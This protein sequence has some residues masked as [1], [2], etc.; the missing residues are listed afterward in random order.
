MS[1][2]EEE[3]MVKPIITPLNANRSVSNPIQEEHSSFIKSLHVEETVKQ[4]IALNE[5]I[6]HAPEITHSKI[7]HIKEELLAGR[8]QIHGHHIAEKILEYVKMKAEPELA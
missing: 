5:I 6:Q 1:T 3:V 8:Y 7:Q 2:L 4:L